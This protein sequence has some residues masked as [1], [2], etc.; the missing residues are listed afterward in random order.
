MVLHSHQHHRHCKMV[1]DINTDVTPL[2]AAIF[3]EIRNKHAVS[4]AL[5]DDE[6]NKLIFHHPDGLR[7]SLGGFVTVKNIFTAY[8]FEI[9]DTIKAKHRQSLSKMEYPYFFTARRL[10]LF[11]E[12]DA[13]IIKLAGGVKEF[14]EIYTESN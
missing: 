9:P 6:L 4:A 13:S 14:L 1:D 7:L 3:V 8:S 2:K 11:S 12:M 5:T 10:I